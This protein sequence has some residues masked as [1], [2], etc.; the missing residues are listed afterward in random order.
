MKVLEALAKNSATPIEIL[1]QLQL[2]ARLERIV[3]ENASFG[4]H[5][6]ENNIG[7]EV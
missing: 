6:Q 5:I 1:Y 4:K 3:K 7:W 2:D